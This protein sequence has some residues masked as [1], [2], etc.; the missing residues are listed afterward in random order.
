MGRH[1][2]SSD[3]EDEA[4]VAAVADEPAAVLTGR[5][6]RIDAP[7]APAP[8]ADEEPLVS[9]DEVAADDGPLGLIAEQMTEPPVDSA[10]EVA[11]PA[12]DVGEPAIEVGE[13]EPEP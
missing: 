7:P 6:A 3:D 10:L 11:E 9:L 13:P 5:H 4:A 1:S 12:V 2:A 8:E